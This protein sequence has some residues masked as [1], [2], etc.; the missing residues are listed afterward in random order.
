M[1]GSLVVVF[2]EST[3]GFGTGSVGVGSGATALVARRFV[4]QSILIMSRV[5]ACVCGSGRVVRDACVL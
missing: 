1:L 5:C 2:S 3:A 4:L